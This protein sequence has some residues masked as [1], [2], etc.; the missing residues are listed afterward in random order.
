MIVEAEVLYNH[1]YVDAD[2]SIG[3]DDVDVLGDIT[4]DTDDSDELIWGALER[5]V[6][7]DCSYHPD[8]LFER[9]TVE[10][11]EGH[12]IFIHD[13]NGLPLITLNYS[14]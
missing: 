3:V 7:V 12:Y 11:L 10:D 13:Q 6:F 9:V 5:G 4:F 14:K 1:A 8:M 2:G